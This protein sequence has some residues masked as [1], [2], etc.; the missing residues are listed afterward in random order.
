LPS[1]PVFLSEEGPRGVGQGWREVVWSPNASGTPSYELGSGGLLA[2]ATTRATATFHE[3]AEPTDTGGSVTFTTSPLSADRVLM[4]HAALHLRATL[5]AFD[6]NFYVEL[7]DVN[8]MG[9]ETL[10]NDGFLKASHRYSDSIPTLVVPGAAIDYVI[11]IRADHYRFVAGDSVRLRISGGK[12]TALVP[13]TQ[14]VEIVIQT[15]AQS[16]LYMAPGW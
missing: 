5:S 16:T 13:V 9:E 1:K 12:S 4:G 8:A 6:A 15:G 14:P 10:V 7:I 3:P 2:P 11:P